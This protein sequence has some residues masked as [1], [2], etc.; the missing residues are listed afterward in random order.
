[1]SEWATPENV[2]ELYKITTPVAGVQMI[3]KAAYMDKLIIVYGTQNPDKSGSEYDRETAYL[4]KDNLMESF[5]G[6]LDFLI[7]V[8]EALKRKQC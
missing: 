4:V 6:V 3:D 1:M 2:S 8:E 7:F 5:I